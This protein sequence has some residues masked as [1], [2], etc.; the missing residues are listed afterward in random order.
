MIG[1]SF[2]DIV[3]ACELGMSSLFVL[4]GNGKNDLHKFN[5]TIKPDHIAEDLFLGAK[6]LIK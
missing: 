5:H 4:S 1:D 3:P 6:H 2:K